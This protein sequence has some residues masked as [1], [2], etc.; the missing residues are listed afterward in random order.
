MEF[1]LFGLQAVYAAGGLAEG[2][3][4][5]LRITAGA[6]AFFWFVQATSL[7]DISAALAWLRVPAPVIAILGMTWRYLSVYE[8]EV[9]R[10]RQARVV[11]LGFAHWRTA[12]VSVAAVGGH[13]VIRAFDHSE[14]TYRAMVSRGYHGCADTAPPVRLPPCRPS[15]AKWLILPVILLLIAFVL[16]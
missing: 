9:A 13:A 4:L 3:I 11:R 2:G 14:R 6:F 12:L 16:A 15:T 5:A 1:T 10:M 8:E 7:P